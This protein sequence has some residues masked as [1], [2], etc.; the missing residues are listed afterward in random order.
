MKKRNLHICQV[1]NFVV[2]LFYSFCGNLLF[3]QK[4]ALNHKV[5][6]IINDFAKDTVL[7]SASISISVIDLEHNKFIG[8]FDPNRSLI[9]A[10]SQKVLSTA[11]LLD[12]AGSDFKYKTNFYLQGMKSVGD[13]SF[14]GKIIVE[15]VADPS[16]CSYAQEGAMGAQELMLILR[17]K[18]LQMGIRKIKG[19]V[20]VNSNYIKDIPENPEWLWYDL[21]NYYGAGCFGLNVYENVTWV[22]IKEER[23]SGLI[24]DIVKVVPNILYP[25]FCSEVVSSV[26]KSDED[27][28][29]LGSSQD[30]NYTLHGSIQCCGSDTLTLKAA[31]PNPP[32]T[33]QRILTIKLKELGIEFL[34]IEKSNAASTKYLLYTYESVPLRQLADRALS[35]SVNLYCESFVH[36][37]GDKV[38]QSTDRKEAL[39]SLEKYWID[40]GLDKSMV[41]EDGSG[42]SPK[43]LLSSAQLAKALLFIS[44]NPA[45]SNFWELLP[46]S[47]VEG[48]LA[49]ILA[50]NKSIKGKLRLKSGSMERVRSYSGYVME[51]DKPKY[52]I[53]LIINH[54][55]CSGSEIKNKIAKFFSKIA[56]Q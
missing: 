38:N 31:I 52:A 6:K 42:L 17:D 32:L 20:V 7:H 50:L 2:I 45:I 55:D 46:E 44:K 11:A 24:C 8:Q 48:S 35:K 51:K 26:T 27:I 33:F 41:L 47:T 25:Y 21:G 4:V 1:S 34:P 10:S 36:T 56:E 43:N 5:Q 19:N 15:G 54:Y 16:F 3:S 40:K 18:L 49:G 14:I 29:V 9:P 30:N 39:Q 23:K 22:S 12:K 37:F 28:F 13:S 53:S